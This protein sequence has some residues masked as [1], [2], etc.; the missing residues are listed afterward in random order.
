MRRLFLILILATACGGE[1]TP[2][3]TSSSP[4]PTEVTGLITEVRFEGDE[5]VAFV[6]EAR[7]DSYDLSIDPE[8]DYG[9][10]LR[11]LEKHR[12]MKL[13]VYVELALRDGTLYAHAILDA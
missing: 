1:A 12:A 6:V 7:E 11:H 4:P 8:Y 13:P 3:A 5:V 10:N 2:A 9:F